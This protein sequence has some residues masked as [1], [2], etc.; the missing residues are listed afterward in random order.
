[1][2]IEANPIYCEKLRA[3]RKDVHE[4]AVSDHDEDDAEF[5]MIKLQGD[6]Y[7]ACSALNVDEKL[8]Q[9]HKDMGIFQEE[10]KV[11]VKVRSLNTLLK[12]NDAE[13]IDVL[14]VDTEGTELDVLKGLDFDRWNPTLIVSENNFDTNECREFLKTKG[15]K[16][17]QRSHVN[18]FFVKEGE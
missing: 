9:Q 8:L 12:D 6:N 1:M 10:T 7:G 2:C 5:T 16:L 18:D 13:K 17:D 14:S 15:Y 4:Y 11:K 3:K